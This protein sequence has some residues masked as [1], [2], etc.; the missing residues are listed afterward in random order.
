M[1]FLVDKRKQYRIND[2]FADYPEDKKREDKY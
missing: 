2:L 1:I